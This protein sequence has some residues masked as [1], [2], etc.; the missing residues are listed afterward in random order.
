LPINVYPYNNLKISIGAKEHIEKP[1]EFKRTENISVNLGS[2]N[3][4]RLVR[5]GAAKKAGP[6]GLVIKPA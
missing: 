5:R 6:F 4:Q 2:V 1:M 3:R